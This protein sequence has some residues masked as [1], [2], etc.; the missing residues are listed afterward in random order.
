MPENVINSDEVLKRRQRFRELRIRALREIRGDD[1]V[2]FG[3]SGDIREGS[4]E[5]V[6]RVV[7]K[8]RVRRRGKHGEEVVEDVDLE[9]DG[10]NESEGEDEGE[11]RRYFRG[12][13]KKKKRKDFWVGES[14]D[15][16]REFLAAQKSAKDDTAVPDGFFDQPVS[17]TAAPPKRPTN[18]SRS[19]LQSFVNLQQ[20]LENGYGIVPSSIRQS[21]AS[22]DR[23]VR[24]SQ[25]SSM[26]PLLGVKLKE[27]EGRDSRVSKGKSAALAPYPAIPGVQPTPASLKKRLK[28]AIRKTP[29]LHVR[30]SSLTTTP[31]PNGRGQTDVSVNRAKTV[32]FPVGSPLQASR[33][34][35]IEGEGPR[36]GNKEPAD[37]R[38]VLARQGDDAVGTSSG[39]V[40]DAMAPDLAEDDEDEVSPGG[41]I[42]RGESS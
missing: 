15:I 35:C 36:K 26:R 30:S 6:K 22:P 37:P 39:A 13:K 12:K 2:V 24:N 11:Q 19:T 27:D 9:S 7:R 4:R 32:H 10:E 21:L 41:V 14:F 20:Q 29:S 42:M 40:E 17:D 1:E 5:G 16:G 34:T 31:D 33:A 23:N 25:T 18:T 8:I 38:A 28:S 3:R